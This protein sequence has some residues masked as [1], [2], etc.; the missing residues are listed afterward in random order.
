MAGVLPRSGESDLAYRIL[1]AQT[2]TR[3]SI[4]STGDSC[5]ISGELRMGN[6]MSH[7]KDC[8]R[9]ILNLVVLVRLLSKLYYL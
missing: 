2:D 1:E 3:R 5:V 4:A 8:E 6:G 7:A 9:R